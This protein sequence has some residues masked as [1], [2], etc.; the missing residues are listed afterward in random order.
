[1][2]TAG[3]ITSGRIIA[4]VGLRL[5]LVL[6]LASVLICYAPGFNSDDRL[7]RSGHLN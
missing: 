6:L 4:R 2:L 1:M 3:W 5:P 7:S